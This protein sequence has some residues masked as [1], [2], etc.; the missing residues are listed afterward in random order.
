MVPHHVSAQPPHNR[1]THPTSASAPRHP[2]PHGLSAAPPSRAS[3]A[4]PLP[5]TSQAVD[6]SPTFWLEHRGSGFLQNSKGTVSTQ[7][8]Q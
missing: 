6:G 2:R 4:Q 3:S 5:E 7:Q 8:I 1:A